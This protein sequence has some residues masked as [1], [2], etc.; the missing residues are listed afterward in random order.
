M[1]QN[2]IINSSANGEGSPMNENCIITHTIRME[3]IDGMFY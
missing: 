2:N 3:R 1:Y